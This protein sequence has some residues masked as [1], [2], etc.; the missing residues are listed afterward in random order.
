MFILAA[1][2]ERPMSASDNRKKFLAA[3]NV[4]RELN[5]LITPRTVEV[6]LI[7]AENNGA[8]RGALEP[9]FPFSQSV[10][11]RHLGRLSERGWKKGNT[12]VP[13]F[14]LVLTTEDYEDYRCKRVFLTPKGI[15]VYSQF[16]QVFRGGFQGV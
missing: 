9:L 4:F 3:W 1:K 6:F 5:H 7:V 15:E 13:G 2:K 11:S 8:T 12:M 14:G 10:L 16:Q